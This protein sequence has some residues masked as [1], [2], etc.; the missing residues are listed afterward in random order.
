M[1][2]H[3]AAQK[4]TRRR[5]YPAYLAWTSTF[6]RLRYTTRP[7]PTSCARSIPEMKPPKIIRVRSG[8][9]ICL[10]NKSNALRRRGCGV[11]G[12][13]DY[14]LGT[15]AESQS[16]GPIPAGA[17]GTPGRPHWHC[18]G[19]LAYDIRRIIR[20][21]KGRLNLRAARPFLRLAVSNLQLPMP[22]LHLS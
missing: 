1:S 18:F 15:R 11:P 14:L 13:T 9:M 10:R 20:R 3:D 2:D 4:R 16:D 17:R 22:R 5:S 21:L 6:L 19:T 8:F 12:S 7:Y